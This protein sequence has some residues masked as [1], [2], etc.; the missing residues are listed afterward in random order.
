M[1]VLILSFLSS[2]SQ[3]N[4][5]P[6]EDALRFPKFGPGLEVDYWRARQM[7]ISLITDQLKSR[8]CQYMIGLL[9]SQQS[10]VLRKWKQ[11]DSAIT[12]AS[13]ESK[14]IN[15][16][17]DSLVPLIESLHGKNP[18]SITKSLAILSSVAN[19]PITATR[20]GILLFLARFFRLCGEQVVIVCL[21]VCVVVVS[22]CIPTQWFVAA[23]R[24]RGA[25]KVEG[26]SA[27]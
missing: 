20:K 24:R 16:I 22:L 1:L 21:Q 23:W 4:G 2:S 18:A 13:N 27:V 11:I 7:H 5:L 26:C 12:D 17:L 25:R 15:R 3:R 19:K 6:S 8:E 10:K 9:I 14:D